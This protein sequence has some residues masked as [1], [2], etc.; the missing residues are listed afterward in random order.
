MFNS[1]IQHQFILFLQQNKLYDKR[2]KVELVSGTFDKKINPYL[3][4]Y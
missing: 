1:K 4:G 2:A 3:S